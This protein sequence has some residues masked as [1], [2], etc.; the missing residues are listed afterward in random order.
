M[1][2]PRRP[3]SGRTVLVLGAADPVAQSAALHVAARGATV[4]AA[5]PDVP[6]V[7][8]TAG[9]IAATGAVGRVIEEAAPPLLGAALVRAAAV[10][11]GHAAPALTDVIVA[12]A[13]FATPASLDAAVATLTAVLP[14]EARVFR[15][16]RT[17]ADGPKAAG[18]RIAD[19]LL[20]PPAPP[21]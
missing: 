2:G 17:P 16:E 10:A 8:L 21:G 20:A 4:V 12:E 5:G 7:I 1:T 13:L 15:A 14:A 6:S 9:L 11:L 19:A 3:L 18:R